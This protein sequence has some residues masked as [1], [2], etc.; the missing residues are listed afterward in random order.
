MGRPH[1]RE[2]RAAHRDGAATRAAGLLAR[3]LGRRS[4]HRP[5]RA[6]PGPARRGPHLLQ[7]GAAV[8]PRAAD[9]LPV[10]A[11]GGRRRVHPGVL[12]RRD[13]GRG[14]RVDVPRLAAHGRDGDRRA[15]HARGDGRRAA[16]TPPCRGCGDNLAVDDADAIEQ[17][18]RYFVVPAARRWRDDPRRRRRRSRRADPA[19]I[20][21]IV[22]AEERQR[23][24]HARGRSTR[25]STPRSSSRSSRCSRPS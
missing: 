25:W 3:R 8:G 15:R 2:D 4:H 24:R 20:A 17:A 5:G 11:V 6:V 9:L 14:Q 16:C 7:P 23:L 22:P 12:R 18:R 21:D 10:R 13:H 19:S 1:G